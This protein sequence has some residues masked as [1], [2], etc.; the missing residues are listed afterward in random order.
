M[1]CHADTDRSPTDGTAATDTPGL[2][3]F[4]RQHLLV[5][6]GEAHRPACHEPRDATEAVL[7]AL[8]VE[9]APPGTPTTPARSSQS[10]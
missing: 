8:F 10:S 7:A 1:H 2:A 3:L 4:A 6:E 5:A 9:R